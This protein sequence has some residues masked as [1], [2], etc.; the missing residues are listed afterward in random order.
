M[1]DKAESKKPLSLFLSYS[2]DDEPKARRLASCLQSLGYAVWWD[3]LIEGGATYARKISVAL[4]EADVVIVLWSAHS[5]ESDWVRDEAAQGRDRR[6]LVP[7]SLDGS[8]PP[9]GF[10][11]YQVIDLSRWHGRKGAKEIVALERAIAA[12]A[13]GEPTPPGARPHAVSRR[14]FLF[15]GAAAAIV[16]AGGGLWL[17]EERGAFSGGSGPLSIAVIPFRNLSGNASEEFFS[18]GL[19][20]EV[21]AA[22]SRIAQ[23]RVLAA[24]SSA[25]ASEADPDPA[26]VAKQLG[27]AYV[28]AGSVQRAGAIG[29]GT[30]RKQRSRPVGGATKEHR[31][32]MET[33]PSS[34]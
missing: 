12:S 24:T 34:F 5:I 3:A 31:K 26:A 18:D 23:L 33:S 21:R 7:L 30:R 10:R 17:A 29:R 20:E 11:Q 28:L 2:R 6:R 8:P 25:K 15:G 22:L 14:P 27:V 32:G 16:A 19:T 13:R 4:D 9:L 1:D